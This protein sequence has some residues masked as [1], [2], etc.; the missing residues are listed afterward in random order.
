MGHQGG[1]SDVLQVESKEPALKEKPF[2]VA[3]IVNE[4]LHKYFERVG[5]YFAEDRVSENAL[6]HAVHRQD[7]NS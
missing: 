7:L 5:H 2:F 3:L 1:F 6:R 4:L